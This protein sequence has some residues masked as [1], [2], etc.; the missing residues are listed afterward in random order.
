MKVNLSVLRALGFDWSRI[1]RTNPPLYAVR[2]SQCEAMTING[3]PCHEGGCPNRPKN[4][5]VEE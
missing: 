4:I 3:T 2:C 5:D 1:L